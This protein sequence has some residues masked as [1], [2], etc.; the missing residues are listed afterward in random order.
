[1]KDNVFNPKIFSVFEITQLF[2]EYSV[3]KKS[4]EFT[5]INMIH[6][7]V[8]QMYLTM[9]ICYLQFTLMKKRMKL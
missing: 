3:I 9:R 1:M 5:F 6:D 2:Q 4:K 8:Y 7:T